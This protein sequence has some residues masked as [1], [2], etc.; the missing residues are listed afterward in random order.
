MKQLDE[1]EQA[2]GIVKVTANA[3]LEDKKRLD[4]ELPRLQAQKQ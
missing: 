4:L 2:V 1:F 3:I